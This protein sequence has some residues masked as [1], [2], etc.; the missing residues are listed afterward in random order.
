MDFVAWPKGQGFLMAKRG[1]II[2]DFH[3]FTMF[4]GVCISKQK[5]F[6]KQ[7]PLKINMEHN[8]GGL[9]QIIFLSKWVMAVRSSR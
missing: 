3:W 8:P 2:N 4:I 9:V 1:Y 6:P 5:R 7:H